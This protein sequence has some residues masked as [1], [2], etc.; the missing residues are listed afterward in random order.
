MYD[1]NLDKCPSRLPVPIAYIQAWDVNESQP[2]MLP[3]AVNFPW[4]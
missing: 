1:K 4:V 2:G 3:Y